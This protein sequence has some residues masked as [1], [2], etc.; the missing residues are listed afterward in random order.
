MQFFLICK[1]DP[2]VVTNSESLIQ[3]KQYVKDQLETIDPSATPHFVLEFTKMTIRTKA[4]EIGKSLREIEATNL[5]LINDDIKLHE[6]LLANAT[7]ADEENDIT[8]HIEQLC[9]EKNRILDMQGK[10]LAWKTKTKW[11]SE[12]EKSN[13]Y[14]LNL[15]KQ[16]G[17]SNEMSNITIDNVNFTDPKE[18]SVAVNSYYDRLYNNNCTINYDEN[19]FFNELF[20]LQAGEAAPITEPL[21]V[22]E[23]WATLRPLKDSAPGPDG[24]SHIYLKKL[25]DIIGPIILNAW[26]YSIATNTLP[27]SYTRSYLRLIPKAGK[28]MTL[29][30]NWRPITLSNCDLK[31]I[32]RAYNQRLISAT[33]KYISTTQTAYIRGRSIVDNVRLINAA[34]Q[35]ANKEPQI[36]GS[37]IALDAQRAFDTV[38]HGYLE[39][40]LGKI[41]L[42]AFIPIFKLLYSK[43]QNDL[44]IDGGVAGSH[45]VTNGVKQGDALSC[46]LFILAM[47]PLIKNIEKNDKIKCIESL[48]LQY[49]WPKV[50]GYA[51]DITCITTNE[52][53][54]KQAIFDEYERFTKMS[55]LRLNADKTE[56]LNFKGIFNGNINLL[57]P[58]NVRY[59]GNS[60]IIVPVKEIKINGILICK[61]PRD[62]KLLNCKTLIEKLDK[63][64]TQWSKRGLSL[65]GKV[66][67]FKTFGLSQF[68]YHFATFEPTDNDWKMIQERI[69]KFMWNKTYT[70]NVAP[71]R[72]KTEVMYAPVIKGGFG[73]I[74]IRE[75]VTALRLRRHFALIK[76]D[77]HPMSLLLKKLTENTGYLASAPS[78]DIDEVLNMNMKILSEKRKNDCEIPA[79]LIETDLVL[80]SNLL[81][82]HILDMT[83][84]RK[85]Q[86]PELRQLHRRGIKTLYDTLDNRQNLSLLLKISDKRLTNAIAILGRVY[87][88]VPPPINVPGTSQ[89]L[90]DKLG[91]W[92]D[93]T[94][95]TSKAIRE[96]FGDQKVG[97]PKIIMMS[98]AERDY[99]FRKLNKIVNVQNK[100]RM[101]RLLY[102]DV[103]CAERTF[104]FGLGES[105]KCRRCFG[106]E[107]IYHLLLE[108][109]YT[110]SVYNI[111]GINSSCI[112]DVL[113]VDL[114]KNELEIRADL[115]GH[116][117]FRYR[118]MPPEILVQTTLER[119]ARGISGSARVAQTAEH[120]L[121]T[122]W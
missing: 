7:S 122:V 84:P 48:A 16:K 76:N 9:N 11:Y 41:G 99:Y 98:D 47:E 66:Q 74:H 82:S 10:Q 83:R 35:L 106:I 25:W 119:H 42:N 15:L 116:L 39:S 71:P 17:V 86:G 28:D 92:V 34:V 56:I 80:Q 2:Q 108:C 33:A 69:N 26:N 120:L 81:Q 95:V 40:I 67:I 32:T 8:L 102:G 49:K 5:K 87:S 59:L 45:N 121:R 88:N 113:G 115:L 97:S 4:L 94:A 105:D 101:L 24:I 114:S 78:L 111:I 13:K 38:N 96:M 23:L 31:L 79:W 57:A 118:M 62:M 19:S 60:F 107:T 89:K 103:Y 68:L 64:F 109:P 65:L 36:S 18:I 43:L 6:N 37:V 75:V 46:T 77:L 85:W 54:C 50:V 112:F 3:L 55:G 90:R 104:R 91:R 73:M 52:V 117:I 72:I 20:T 12:G 58:T 29:L 21:T 61:N 1:L 100:S 93:D 63:H 27:P 14:F 22:N 110:R 30:K 44:L 70:G 51:D 53:E